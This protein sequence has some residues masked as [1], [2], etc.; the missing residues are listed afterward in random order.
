MLFTTDQQ[1]LEDLN[2]F[3]KHGG[4]SIYQIYNRTNTRGGALLLK[5]MFNYPL[6]DEQAINRRSGIIQY[7]AGVGFSFPLQSS[8]FDAVEPYMENTDERT[9][10]NV[11]DHSM[12]RKLTNLIALDADTSAIQ[13]GVCT[14]IDLLKSLNIFISSLQVEAG[15]PYQADRDAM[16]QLLADPSFASIVKDGS[17]KLSHSEIAE[18]DVLFR[19]RYRDDILKLLRYVYLLDVYCAVAKVAVSRGFVFPKALPGDTNE[20]HLQDV[21]HPQVKNA[22]PNSI[23]ITPE[24]NVIFLTGA[25]MAG[26]STFMKSLSIALFLAHMGFPVAASKMEF[27]VLDGI[28]T[29][30]N[31]PDNLG[32]GA[33]H[34][35]AEVLRA[36][37]MAME[38][39]TKKLFVLFDELFRG[40]NV[41]DAG[42]ATVAFT[43]A[44]AGKKDS[45]FVI[46]T[47]II[48]AGE[49][50]KKRCENISFIY[51]PTIMDGNQPIYT[52]KLEKGITADRHGMV[53]INNEGILEVLNQGKEPK[54]QGAQVENQGVKHFIADKQTIADLNI[55]GKYKP[56]SIYSLFNQVRTAGGER[57]LQ[58]MFQNPFTDH[59]KINERSAMFRYFHENEYHFSFKRERFE[60]MEAY[61]GMG[62]NGNFVAALSTMLYHK[63]SASFLRDEQYNSLHSGLLVTIEVLNSFREFLDSMDGNSGC[64]Y[65]SERKL[66]KQIFSDNSL[67]W[68]ATEQ[69]TK[70]FSLLEFA[71]YDFLLKHTLQ[72]EMERLLLGM[73]LVD[74]YLSVGAVARLNS[75]HYA[76]AYPAGDHFIHTTALRHPGLA[77]GI[78]NPVSFQMDQNLMFLT[79]ANMA[80]KSTF[81][82]AC[83]IA[84]YLSHMGFPVA[85]EEMAFSVLDGIYSSINV[86]DDLNMGHSHFYAEV[87]RVKHVAEE[88]ASG[89][90]MVVLF[91]ELFKGTNVKDAYDGTLSVTAAFAKYRNC[92]YIVSTHIIEVGQALKEEGE[93]INFT[94]LPTV[95]DGNVPRY[96][97]L[98]QEGIT[99]DRQGMMIIENEGIL[100]VLKEN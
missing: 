18:Y 75:F 82:K 55:L 71:K 72:K 42:E 39:K 33:S 34:F 78:A 87:L 9:K 45:V 28:Y 30:I 17:G 80:G 58:E 57:M 77:K 7:F 100:E 92:F 85:A 79:G 63:F 43:E 16:A 54:R 21:Y 91:D 60:Q 65:E 68:L 81:M 96:T 5:E 66:L 53:I 88:V 70:T 61:L 3:G 51:L 13:K 73:H 6:S 14:L 41:K 97:Y 23:V 37:K 74:V 10:L 49:L 24:S 12:T 95:M 69:N 35:Y 47:H 11:Q 98:L 62:T 56:N 40:T 1:T 84:V 99:T 89:K 8:H 46:S 27:S 50:L 22:V 4:D 20:V 31:L 29:T 52:Y 76:T 44:F 93:N 59:I 90:N 83:G 19:F 2:I 86:A 67:Q 32:M 64:P 36:K 48:E 15:H 94:Y 38:L 26:K 25:N